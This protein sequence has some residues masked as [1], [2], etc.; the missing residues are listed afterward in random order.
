LFYLALLL[1]LLVAGTILWQVASTVGITDNVIKLIK[2]LGDFSTY[3]IDGGVILKDAALAGL[4]L[5]FFG[6]FLN[7]LMCVLYNLISDVVGGVRLEMFDE[8][9]PGR[10]RRPAAATVP[11]GA[12]GAPSTPGTPGAPGAPGDGAAPDGNGTHPAPDGRRLSRRERANA[13]T[14]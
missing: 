7:A 10:R 12:N 14:N 2:K 9:V 3:R 4:I 8:E 1:T 6:A 5:A 13:R 11:V